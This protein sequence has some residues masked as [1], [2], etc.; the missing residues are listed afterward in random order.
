[1]LDQDRSGSDRRYR[2]RDLSGRRRRCTND[3]G[4][5]LSLAKAVAGLHHG[6]IALSDCMP[7]LG[8]KVSIPVNESSAALQAA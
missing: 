4:L 2:D 5:G 1:M 3:L 6:S 7:G 8:V